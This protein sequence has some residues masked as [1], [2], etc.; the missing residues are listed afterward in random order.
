MSYPPGPP[1]GQR[2][3]DSYPSP[4]YPPAPYPPGSYHPG[5]YPP[6]QA[7]PQE[8][9]VRRRGGCRG[10][11]I[12]CLVACLAGVVLIV[13]AIAAGLYV[14]RQMYP[15]TDSVQGAV[16]CAV[17]RT[18]LNNLETLLAQSDLTEAEKEEMRRELRQQR[19][20]FEEQCGPLN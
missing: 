18:F 7:P 20:A 13:V 4:G 17:M 8:Q 10:C 2:P 5:Q 11:L 12:G 6:G 15:T 19:R 16:G 14:V 1:G 3:P 9:Q